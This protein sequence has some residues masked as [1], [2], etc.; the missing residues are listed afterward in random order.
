MSS[1]ALLIP[2]FALVLVGLT[3]C[4]LTTGG[5]A[6]PQ[7]ARDTLYRVLDRTEATIGGDWV[8][9]DD[10]TPRGCTFPIW[11]Q[12]TLYPGLRTAA[13]IAGATAALRRVEVLWRRLGYSLETSRVGAVIQLRGTASL[14][15]SLQL[16]FGPDGM[17]LQGESECRPG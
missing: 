4:A 17:T 11:T 5:D 7:A 10:P 9:A 3:G 1:R 8:V 14:S 13:P 12:G 2:A 15:R 6:D 16:R